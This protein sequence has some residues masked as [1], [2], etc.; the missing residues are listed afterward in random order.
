MRQQHEQLWRDALG[1]DAERIWNGIR[2]D[3][4]PPLRDSFASE[5]RP[6]PGR[7]LLAAAM[8]LVLVTGMWNVLLTRQLAE[9]RDDYVMATLAAGSPANRL[10]VLH[11]LGGE[12]LS[13]DAVEALKNLVRVSQDPNIQLAALDLLLDSHALS[14]DSEIQTLLEQVRHNSQFIEAAVR[15]RSVR[16]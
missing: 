10:A 16:T 8:V 1:D 14:A 9:I 6:R 7:W 2:E 4:A 5:V 3:V 12:S 15:A 11:R 13:A